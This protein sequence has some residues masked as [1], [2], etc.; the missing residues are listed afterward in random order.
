MNIKQILN[1]LDNE[2]ARLT[3]AR[4]LLTG[5]KGTI[6]APKRR[7]MSAASRKRIGDV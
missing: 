2:I 3:Q 6:P 1:E 7:T 4:G 5:C